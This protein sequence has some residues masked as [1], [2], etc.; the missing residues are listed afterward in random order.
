MCFRATVEGARSLRFPTLRSHQRYESTKVMGRNYSFGAP[1]LDHL[2]LLLDTAAHR[3]HQ[4]ATVSQLANQG[5][6]YARRSCR[7]QYLVERRLL[8]HSDASVAMHDM[9]VAIAQLR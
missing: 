1:L 2:Y 7:N 3:Y 8:R 9:D 6:G 4:P 5:V